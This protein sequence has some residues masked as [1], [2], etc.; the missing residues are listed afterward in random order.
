MSLTRTLEYYSPTQKKEILP[1]T[2]AWTNLEGFTLSEVN[3]KSD[4]QC[5]IS[6]IRGI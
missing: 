5:M 6:P 2:T 4:K 3:Q 1:S